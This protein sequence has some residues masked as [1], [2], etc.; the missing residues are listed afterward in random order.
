VFVVTTDEEPAC[1][2]PDPLEAAREN[3][4]EAWKYVE[5]TRGRLREVRTYL[6]I[7]KGRARARETKLIAIRDAPKGTAAKVLRKMAGQALKETG[8]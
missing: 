2:V 5:S 7:W 1:P 6:D 3:A 8:E 4:R